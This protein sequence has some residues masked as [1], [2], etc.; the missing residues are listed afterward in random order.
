M[1]SEVMPQIILHI[2]II[3]YTIQIKEVKRYYSTV[4]YILIVMNH[5]QNNFHIEHDMYGTNYLHIRVN[6]SSINMIKNKTD[7]TVHSSTTMSRH[8]RFRRFITL[9][10]AKEPHE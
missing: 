6:V 7:N 1:C 5:S 2:C 10:S 9:L 8:D 4:I 3:L